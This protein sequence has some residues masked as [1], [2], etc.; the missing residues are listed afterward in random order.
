MPQNG[1]FTKVSSLLVDQKRLDIV[2]FKKENCDSMSLKPKP[3]LQKKRSCELSVL[4]LFSVHMI[5]LCH[6]AYQNDITPHL[7]GNVSVI[8]GV[9]EHYSVKDGEEQAISSIRS[10][11]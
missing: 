4:V 5:P 11:L 7:H 10:V 1:S 9:R 3:K 6:L 2:L 8:T